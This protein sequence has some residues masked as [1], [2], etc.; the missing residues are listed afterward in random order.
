MRLLPLIGFLW[1]RYSNI[2]ESYDCPNA[3][4]VAVKD[5]YKVDCHLIMCIFSGRTICERPAIMSAS[6]Q[7]VIRL[8]DN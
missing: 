4:E 3:G 8:H 7:D 1:Y 6:N 5:I 2:S